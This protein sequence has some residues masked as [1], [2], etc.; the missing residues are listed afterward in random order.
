[1]GERSIVGIF[2][3]SK[4]FLSAENNFSPLR[5]KTRV[6]TIREMLIVDSNTLP[7]SSVRAD[8]QS[9]IGRE[10]AAISPAKQRQICITDARD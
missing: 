7:V 6:R 8:K 5:K 1:M 4:N 3:G 2:G 10:T 9:R